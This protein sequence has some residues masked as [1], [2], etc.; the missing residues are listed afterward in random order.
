MRP[1]HVIAS[2]VL[3]RKALPRVPPPTGQRRRTGGRGSRSTGAASTAST[4]A[5]VPGDT[6]TGLS[7]RPT[8]SGTSS[9]RAPTR[10]SRSSSAARGRVEQGGERGRG[11]EPAGV[12]VG[13]GQHVR[14]PR[15]HGGGH[16]AGPERQ[17]GADERVVGDADGDVDPGGRHRLD[18][19]GPG[20]R[21]ER[22]RHAVE[23]GAEIVLV[24]DVEGQAPGLGLGQA[25]ARRRLHRHGVADLGR[26]PRRGV[27]VG[28]HRGCHHRQAGGPQHV[29]PHAG[30][31]RARRAVPAVAGTGRA[32]GLEH[33]GA[34]GFGIRAV[35]RGQLALGRG[36]PC[37][38]ARDAPERVGGVV[39]EVEH[40]HLGRP[41][42]PRW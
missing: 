9:T 19:D 32:Q 8:I 26:G 5:A 24:V 14:L 12:E 34:G 35:G 40:G 33:P 31:E 23:R 2:R 6:I 18:H 36:P 38:V 30:R 20:G 15:G 17:H 11:H 1:P 22:A 27:G 16:P 3:R 28:R 4:I 13:E 41:R 39:G 42:R 21:A 37:G 7:S 10:S 29:G 25:G